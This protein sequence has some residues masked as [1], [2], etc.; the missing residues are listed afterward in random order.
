[1]YIILVFFVLFLNFSNKHRTGGDNN[2]AWSG[3][4]ILHFTGEQGLVSIWNFYLKAIHSRKM[5]VF[6]I[7]GPTPEAIMS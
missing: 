7:R 5:F 6:I 2:R 4:Y 3:R 1:M